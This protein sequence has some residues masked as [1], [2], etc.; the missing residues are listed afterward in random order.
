MHIANVREKKYNSFYLPRYFHWQVKVDSRCGESVIK[1]KIVYGR[2]HTQVQGK[3]KIKTNV[4]ENETRFRY[5]KNLGRHL[6]VAKLPLNRLTMERDVLG[7]NSRNIHQK[8][9]RSSILSQIYSPRRL[10][11][12]IC[13]SG[14]HNERY[15][16]LLERPATI[17]FHTKALSYFPVGFLSFS[18]MC[19]KTNT[20]VVQPLSR[21]VFCW[22][23]NGWFSSLFNVFCF[24]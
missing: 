14:M 18:Y 7:T 6:M 1:I 21:L 11:V 4:N 15:L 10:Y 20:Y 17:G 3:K 19:I 12:C 13:S 2:R 8:V 24:K 9:E 16:S 5:K 22:K 23:L